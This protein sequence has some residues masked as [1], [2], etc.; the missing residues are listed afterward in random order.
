[1][2]R[3]SRDGVWQ[4]IAMDGDD[5][6]RG[7]KSPHPQGTKGEEEEIDV[8]SIY[9]GHRDIDRESLVRN[10]IKSLHVHMTTLLASVSRGH[11][12]KGQSN[13]GFHPPLILS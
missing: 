10:M 13:F 3:D 9:V 8:I 6:S 2:L 11:W 7:R 1:M 4:T 12:F 5:S